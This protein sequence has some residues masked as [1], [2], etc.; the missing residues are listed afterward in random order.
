MNQSSTAPQGIKVNVA[1][2]P[3]E[4]LPIL[5]RRGEAFGKLIE[6][7]EPEAGILFQDSDGEPKGTAVSVDFDGCTECYAGWAARS[8]IWWRYADDALQGSTG[9]HCMQ[10]LEVLH[11][12]PVQKVSEHADLKMRFNEAVRDLVATPS[13]RLR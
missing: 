2:I 9:E 6:W 12:P 8:K 7:F 4:G 10:I 11:A 5:F 3:A 1:D 13:A